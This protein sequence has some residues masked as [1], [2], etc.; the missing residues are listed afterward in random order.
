MFEVPSPAALAVM[1]DA[2]L[3]TAVAAT[4][5]CESAVAARRLALIGEVTARQCD[6][7]DDEIAYRLIDGWAVAKADISAACNL[8]P[9]AAS[10]QMRIAVALRNRLPRTAAVFARG[11][12]SA[13][14]VDA[15]T[16]RTRLVEDP[17]AMA[18]IDAAI[19]REAAN[20][21]TKSEKGLVD[22]VDL[23]VEKFDPDAVI[24]S[25]P[26][27]KD[28]YIEFDDKDDPNGVSS[29]WGR[30]RVTDRKILEQRLDDLAATVCA[31]DPRTRRERRADA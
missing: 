14:V 9:T 12:V 3:T 27:A 5:R 11:E 29:F 16:W 2:M 31:N 18:L 22:A 17:D 28:C 23:W 25:D 26:T 7:E 19:A 13:T 21:G 15:I 24:R 6:D 30:L 10:K 4:T 8:G 20:Y 1:S